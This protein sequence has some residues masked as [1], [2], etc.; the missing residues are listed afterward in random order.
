MRELTDNDLL[1]IELRKSAS[2]EQ[3]DELIRAYRSRQDSYPEL[4]DQV[5][6]LKRKLAKV[7]EVA[8]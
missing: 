3:L 8:A 4:R 1:D 5:E 2:G 7:Q 6:R